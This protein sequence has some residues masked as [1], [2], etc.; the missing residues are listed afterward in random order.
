VTAR[1]RALALA[2]LAV[3]AVA[4]PSVAFAGS[5]SA[6]PTPVSTCT[7]INQNG[8]YVLGQDLSGADPCIHVTSDDVVFEGNNHTINGTGTGHGIE[9]DAGL[10]NVT[11]DNV[12]VTY[13]DFGVLLA[14][15]ES[16][17]ANVT[18]A[19]VDEGVRVTGDRN[20][21]TAVDAHGLV[22]DAGVRLVGDAT[23]FT[24]GTV[25]GQ[26]GVI[27]EGDDDVVRDVTAVDAN[28]AGFSVS[29][30]NNTLDGV[31][32]TGTDPQY[33]IAVAKYNGNPAE[34]TVRNA[35]VAGARD[36]GVSLDTTT[37]TTLEN[38]T[39][40]GTDRALSVTSSD[41]L[42]VRNS[43]FH[44]AVQGVRI[45]GS[46]DALFD[47]NEVRNTT[48]D[49]VKLDSLDNF[50]MTDTTIVNDTS[51]SN[52][53]FAL[54][55]EA[56]NDSVIART[57]VRDAT[58]AVKFIGASARTVLRDGTISN[59]GVPLT[60]D[61]AISVVVENNTITG[62]GAA[63]S[64]GITVN[65]PSD[66]VEI[67]NNTVSGVDVG[68]NLYRDNG[69]LLRGNTVL[70]DATGIHAPYT[71]N[72]T[73]VRNT[74][75]G[76]SS[77][78]I[79]IASSA[80]NVT[81]YDNLLNNTNNVRASSYYPNAWNT[82]LR[83]GTNVVG[84]SYLGGNYYAEPDG[85]GYSETC[86]DADA[87]DIC[88]SNR[89]HYSGN[90]DYYPLAAVS[91][92]GGGGGSPTVDVAPTTLDVG[93]VTV[94]SSTTGTVVVSNTGSA[95]LDVTS[96]ALSGSDAAR[97]SVSNG[98]AF[99]LA[100]SATRTLTVTYS[101]TAVGANSSTLTVA[102]N[103]TASPSVAV[104]LAGTGVATPNRNPV[105]DF[106]FTP[107][108]PDT[109]ESVSFDA[110]ASSDADG[111]ITA[112]A[113]DFDADGTTDA[114]VAAPTHAFATAGAH[115]VTLTVTD[116]DGATNDTTRTVTVARTGSRSTG[117]G[118]GAGGSGGRTVESRSLDERGSA[119]F[120]LRSGSVRGVAIAVPGSTGDVR[121]ENLG[122]L[123]GEL[124][125]THGTLVSAMEISAPD[126]TT[127]NA[128]LRFTLGNVT[129]FGVDPANLVVE[130]YVDGA[131]VVLDTTV[132]RADAGYVVTAETD[133]FSP[134]A[135]TSLRRAQTSTST[136]SAPTDDTTETTPG[137]TD[138]ADDAPD[139]ETTDSTTSGASPGFDA[140][141]ALFALAIAL[142]FARRRA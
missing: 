93:D 107:A 81:I 20:N 62:T 48:R 45:Y 111:T 134:F 91:G 103:D 115:D 9:V 58:R 105:A 84:G 83:A 121:V 60:L 18:A 24:T 142:L 73:F 82:T 125:A 2:A 6:A 44:D 1:R 54:N 61:D 13:W 126:P 77:Y 80:A 68:I 19:T 129:R 36:Y 100:P 72:A 10:T 50:T 7:T 124:G 122:G 109:G 21:V 53:Y 8:T 14:S 87:N 102:S 141:L 40:T 95:T 133:G 79:D 110:S 4:A 59:A 75:R 42:V 139:D 67:R 138:D 128:T 27:V 16:T 123:P 39:S 37:N 38:V 23:T 43:T 32:V 49:G 41:G 76:A 28:A 86:T 26:D 119:T 12:T 74:V 31:L 30:S 3:V 104:S 56:V 106:S 17:V 25:T 89:T 113:W 85:T 131:W 90:V 55:V 127:G 34:N 130:H 97:F 5:A 33:G 116:D 99:T 29:G 132:E 69:T 137:P 66:G 57:T 15:N 70:A 117:G 112:W 51:S 71:E 47:A 120:V 108:S 118:S 22:R 63:D 65:D 98:G 92:G 135:V 96:T 11:V 78:G 136:T 64:R 140:S 46:D 52:T 101:P 94:G 35:T 114:L 88:D